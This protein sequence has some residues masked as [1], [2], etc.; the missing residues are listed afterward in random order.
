MKIVCNEMYE[1]ENKNMSSCNSLSLDNVTIPAVCN[2]KDVS[3][4][5]SYDLMNSI[6]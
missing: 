5:E 4:T 6:K 3:Y 1:K 2:S